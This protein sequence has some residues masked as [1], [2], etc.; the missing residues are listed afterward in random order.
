MVDFPKSKGEVAIAPIHAA[1]GVVG[2]AYREVAHQSL[3][4]ED[5]ALLAPFRDYIPA[6]RRFGDRRFQT[7][8]DAS[9]FA[10]DL[11]HRI[12]EHWNLD[13]LRFR[14]APRLADAAR[15]EMMP[16]VILGQPKAF[17]SPRRAV[18][19]LMHEGVHAVQLDDAYLYLTGYSLEE[20]LV[21]PFQKF[22][23]K[24]GHLW[25]GLAPA[26][27]LDDL[28]QEPFVK[29]A[30]VIAD[31][32]GLR[33]H[34]VGVSEV[35]FELPIE[36][37][38]LY[39]WRVHRT[40]AGI[41]WLQDPRNFHF[42]TPSEERLQ[43]LVLDVGENMRGGITGEAA[44]MQRPREK[45]AY[46]IEAKVAWELRGGS[47]AAQGDQTIVFIQRADLGMGSE[48]IPA[49]APLPKEIEGMPVPEV[50][51]LRGVV[52][53]PE[54]CTVVTTMPLE[55]PLAKPLEKYDELLNSRW[56]DFYR[57]VAYSKTLAAAAHRG[58]ALIAGFLFLYDAEGFFETK[59]FEPTVGAGETMVRGA[60]VTLSAA[61]FYAAMQELLRIGKLGLRSGGLGS[62]AG[63]LISGVDVYETA[64]RYEE[65]LVDTT[66][67]GLS[68]TG[69]GLTGTAA[70][71]FVAGALGVTLAPVWI[72]VGGVSVVG[73]LGIGITRMVRGHGGDEE[74]LQ[75]TKK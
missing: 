66:E 10:A 50:E 19:T 45:G 51:A 70:T 65:G 12:Q 59:A 3:L 33:I 32:T 29:I 53:N 52:E 11:F 7:G 75:S 57:K 67:L 6:V 1:P 42:P 34:Q 44:D 17:D 2:Y 4:W 24:E 9:G 55:G 73:A 71:I 74:S 22:S 40:R 8:R 25:K 60:A 39:L 14:L 72:V 5:A 20:D 18:G 63:V 68:I 54:G 28:K 64:Q 15:Y 31:R 58:G 47:G 41:L 49:S 62:G 23:K 35:F 61:T 30:E 48:V 13:S 36:E 16:N 38:V 26:K 46:T 21:G 43:A 69:L 56:A 37:Q 27:S